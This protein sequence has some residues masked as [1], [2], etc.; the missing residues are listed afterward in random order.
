MSRYF[1]YF[2]RFSYDSQVATN[3]TKRV[4]VQERLLSDPYLFLPYTIKNDESPEEVAYFYYGD[5]SMS[6]IILVANDI[7]DPYEQW[8][9]SQ[10]KFY[11]YLIAKYATQAGT[12]GYPVVAWTQNET[13]TDNVVYYEDA[14]GTQISPSTYTLSQTLDPEFT[15]GNWT[16]VR[17]Y[18]YEDL[19]NEA[20]RNIRVVDKR[21]V[22]QIE[23]ELRNIMNGAR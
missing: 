8:P 13:I 18:E 9:M 20:K 1:R 11:K 19:A 2:P 21:Y 7:L 22:P 4:R 15:A 5:A 12:T 17:V 23:S 3:I 16:P 6:W 10:D 14:T